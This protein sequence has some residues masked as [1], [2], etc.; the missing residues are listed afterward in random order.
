MKSD[1]KKYKICTVVGTRPEIIRLS[2][3][4]QKLD[5]NFDHYLVHTGQNF[6]KEL[7]K[8]FFNDLNLKLPRYQI[9]S[10]AGGP[11]P[12]ISKSL[13]EVDKILEKIK[14]DAFFVLGDTNSALTAICAKKK[15]IPIFHY[16]AG[17]RCFDNRVPEEAN[18]KII[19][20]ISDINFTYSSLSKDNLLKEGL[21]SD[22][23]INIGSP[24]LEVLNFYKDKIS[25]SKILNKLK[26]KKNNYI[27]ISAHREENI[28]TSSKLQNIFKIITY[29]SEKYKMPVIVS[30][31]PRLRKKILNYKNK[32]VFFYKPFS[33]TDYIQLQKSSKIV[34]SDSGTI[35]EESSILDFDAINL[36]EA[37]ERPESVER[38]VTIMSGLNLKNVI[39]ALNYYDKKKNNRSYNKKI[40]SYSTESVSEVI[41]KNII[42]YINYIKQNNY[43]ENIS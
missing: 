10:F 25:R 36:R 24:M 41:V 9:K 18:R 37:H 11:I 20:I 4:L 12:T 14:P 27:L 5:K 43:K 19:D 28:E 3:I 22:R 15:K 32:N 29:L 23:V 17:N 40:L 34:V 2:V 42:S 26:I 21:G 31:H 30:T 6:D 39:N 13:I 35:N 8:N 7:S 38:G 33:F 16:E 1:N